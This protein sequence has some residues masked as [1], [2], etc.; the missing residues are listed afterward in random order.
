[1][2]AR[3]NI[4]DKE[5][6]LNYLK[7]GLSTRE[8]DEQMEYNSVVSK[9]WRSWKI[10][11][12]YKIDSTDRGR[13][14]CFRKNEALAIVRNIL[15]AKS[16]KDVE[17]I[18]ASSK[19]RFFEKYKGIYIVADSDEKVRIV[20]SGEV[21]NITQSFFSPLKKVVGGCQ[22]P[23]CKNT[24]LD[25]VHLQK[26]RPEHLK[27]ACTY[28]R[29]SNTNKYDVYQILLKYIHLHSEKKSL[30]FLCKKHHQELGL[31]ERVGGKKLNDFRK[32]ILSSL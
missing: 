13:L 21:R 32:I 7:S 24:N 9:G 17:L 29:I 26:S 12:Q 14:F 22:F 19:P 25:T 16:R 20:L 3:T 4:S 30:C 2:R 8:L 27:L 31:Y 10:L 1:M 11:R 6:L 5:L 23:K 15:N 18:L 28:G